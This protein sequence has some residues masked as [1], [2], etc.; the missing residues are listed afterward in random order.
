MSETVGTLD[1]KI[2]RLERQLKLLEHQGV[3]SSA[4][5]EH[6]E[7]LKMACSKA[8]Q[9]LNRLNRLRRELAQLVLAA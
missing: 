7:A 2:A 3:L 8:W 4:Y 5:P 6:Q 1:L 9:E